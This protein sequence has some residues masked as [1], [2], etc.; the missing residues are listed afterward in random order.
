MDEE[1][2]I[3]HSQSHGSGAELKPALTAGTIPPE[4]FERLYLAPKN[5]IHGDLRKTVSFDS[6]ADFTDL[7]YY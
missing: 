6:A 1:S 2:N 4:V 7:T 3:D 5:A